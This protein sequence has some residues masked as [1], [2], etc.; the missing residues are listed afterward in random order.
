[1]NRNALHIIRFIALVLVQVLLVNHIRLG[2]YV[3]PYIYL[4]FIML[5]PVTMPKW[6]VLLLGFGLGLSIDLFTGTLGLHAGA[7][8][9]MAFCRPTILRIV[10]GHQKLEN[11]QEPD[12]GQ[13]GGVWFLRYAVCMV[14]VHHFALFFLESFSFHLILQVLLR[15]LLSAP[16]SI[17]LIMMILYIFN[18]EKKREAK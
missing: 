3:H 1:M 2:G 12:L 6:Q 18:P 16:V 7:T 10:S 17:F 4:I 9:L 8:T 13:L 14:L 11:V 5:L 15:I